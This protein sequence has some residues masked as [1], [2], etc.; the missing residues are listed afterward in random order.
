[1]NELQV[2]KWDHDAFVPQITPLIVFRPDLVMP[3]GRQALTGKNAALRAALHKLNK[4]GIPFEYLERWHVYQIAKEVK[5]KITTRKL[6][7]SGYLIG[8]AK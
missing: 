8:L 6:N 5:I 1:M 7:G 4:T 2:V 3:P